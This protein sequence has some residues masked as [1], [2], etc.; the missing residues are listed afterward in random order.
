MWTRHWASELQ[1]V[2][3]ICNWMLQKYC[4]YL[5]EDELLQLPRLV[6][7]VALPWHDICNPSTQRFCNPRELLRLP[8]ISQPV[9]IPAPTINFFND[10]DFQNALAPQH[11]ANF[12]GLNFQKCSENVEWCFFFGRKSPR[13]TAWCKF[14]DWSSSTSKIIFFYFVLFSGYFVFFVFFHLNIIF[15][16]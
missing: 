13:A 11:G 4:A 15:M 9:K 6:M 14:C 16:L 8:R 12:A 2:L 5:K 1:Y 7:K 3:A 10:V